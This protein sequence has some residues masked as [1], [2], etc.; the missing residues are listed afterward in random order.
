LRL[1]CNSQNS[2]WTN[3]I[4][5]KFINKGYTYGDIE[6]GYKNLK[7]V[8]RHYKHRSTPYSML[9]PILDKKCPPNFFGNR[10]S[11][12]TYKTAEAAARDRQKAKLSESI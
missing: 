5:D 8:E 2:A 6:Y 9:K 1:E 10:P 12:C 7:E 3:D 11:D 4:I